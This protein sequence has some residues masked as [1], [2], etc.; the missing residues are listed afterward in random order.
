MKYVAALL[1]GI[2]TGALLLVSLLYFNPLASRT[3]VS[4]LS[5]ASGRQLQ[6]VFGTSAPG[7]VATIGSGPTAAAPHPDSAQRLWEPAIEHTAILVAPLRT[8]RGLPAGVGVRFST[9]AEEAGLLNGVYPV[10]SA[11]QLWLPEHGGAMVA[12][13][14]NR[15]GLLR[16]VVVPAWLDSAD[17]WRGT[18]IGIMTRGPNALGTGRLVGGS[19]SLAGVTGETVEALHVRAWSVDRGPVDAEGRLTLALP[20]E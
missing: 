8:S 12:Q 19:G 1:A 18:W 7:A 4:P 11:W 16:N 9:V 5:V 3:A 17:S 14:E 6:F 15:Y 2:L 10:N 20:E 13:T